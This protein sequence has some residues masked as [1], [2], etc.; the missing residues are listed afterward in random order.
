MCRGGICV[1]RMCGGVY[2]YVVYMHVFVIITQ[3][4]FNYRRP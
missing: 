1:Y 2:M 3:L 4:L